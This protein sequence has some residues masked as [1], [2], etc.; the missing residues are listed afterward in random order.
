ME[1]INKLKKIFEREKIDGYI[2][3]KNDEFFGEYTPDYNDRLN[4]ISGFT[5]SYGFALVLKNKNYLFVDGRYT[6]QANNQCGKF[7]KII[8]IPNK[9]P[10]DILREK[11]LSIGFDPNLFTEKSL[12]IFFGKSKIKLKPIFQNLIDKIWKRKIVKNKS[13][14][15][16]LPSEAADEKYQLKINKVAKYLKKKRS[17]FLFVTASENNAWLLNIRGR[18]T[19]YAPIPHSYVLIEKNRNISFFCNL[20]K[21]S[22]TLRRSFKQIKFLDVKDCA[23][24]L[25]KIESKKLIIDSNSC[26]FFLKNLIDKKNKILNLQ[27]PIYLFKAIKGKQEIENIK[28]AHIYDGVALTKYLFWLKK[29][30]Y[31]KN[32]TEITASKKLLKFRKKNKKFKF[33]SFPTISGT[34]PNGAIIHYKATHK[35]DRKLR[36]GDIYLVDSGGQYEFGT[37]D[38]T[39]TIS[40]KNSNKRI[41]D[42]FTRVL[43]GHIA[44]SNFKLKKNTSGSE[45]DTKARKYL[46]QIGLNYAH[47]TG[48]GVGYFLNVHEGPHAISKKNKVNFKGGM[49]VSNEPGYY[50]KNKFGIRI[51]NLIYVKENNKKMNF[52]NLTM[53]PIDKDLIVPERLDKKEKKWINNY[54][55]TVFKNLKSSMNKVDT[56]ELKKACS[57][58]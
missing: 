44:V 5:G 17:D 31:K 39:R 49:I 57:A 29:N 12:F 24:T 30:F 53:A 8:T 26:S 23:K 33:L 4:F 38:V 10:S 14:F 27:D 43:K 54:H 37:T 50:E 56:L 3:P 52:E 7:F 18:D 9:M 36:K 46:K 58:I 34:G 16:L 21:V 19:K 41:K 35:T 28:K 6:L 25:F 48:H 22:S 20:K 13:K 42:I 40:L 1:K 15:Y 45:I 2:I 55:K 11:K 51:E 47:G 32:I